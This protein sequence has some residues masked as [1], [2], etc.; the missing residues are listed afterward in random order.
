M[1]NRKRKV[2]FY[3]LSLSKK[4]S[5]NRTKHDLTSQEIEML[6]VKILDEMVILSNGSRAKNI[7]SLIG[8]YVIEII[9]YSNHIAFMKIGQQNKANTVALRDNNTLESVSVPMSPTQSLELFTYCI[10][11]FN[12][13]V[14][15]YIGINGAPRVSILRD[16]F[17]NSMSESEDVH[18]SLASITTNDILTAISNKKIVSKLS[19]QIAVPSDEVLSN[20]GVSF[21]DFDSLRDVRTHTVTLDLHSRR[22]RSIFR[23]KDVFGKAI[24]SIKSKFGDNLRKLSVNAKD[25]GENMQTYDLLQYCFTKTVLINE[26]DAVLMVSDDFK[27]VLLDVYFKNLKEILQYI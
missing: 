21:E 26:D 5:D 3:L 12:T 11:D 16:F 25:E 4:H 22:N 13:Q 2:S 14:I 7:N 1:A 17:E 8:E 9:E 20:I 23:S 27:R 19:I 6:F 10:L 24:A 15:S 18:A